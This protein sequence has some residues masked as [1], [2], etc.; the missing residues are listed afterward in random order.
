MPPVDWR[1]EIG[2][3]SAFVEDDVMVAVLVDVEVRVVRR[4]MAWILAVFLW[5]WRSMMFWPVWNT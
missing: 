2:W 5:R 1:V 4:F 3:E